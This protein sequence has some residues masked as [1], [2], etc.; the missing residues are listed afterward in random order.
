MSTN[1]DNTNKSTLLHDFGDYVIDIN[2]SSKPLTCYG[3]NEATYHGFRKQGEQAVAVKILKVNLNYE[4]RSCL[5]KLLRSI[6]G[7]TFCGHLP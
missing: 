4:V 5:T 1:T 6:R 7:K 2:T 3:V